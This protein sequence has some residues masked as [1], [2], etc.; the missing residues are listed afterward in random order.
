MLAF[1][2][3][4]WFGFSHNPLVFAIE[5]LLMPRYLESLLPDSWS[6]ALFVHLPSVVVPWLL[7]LVPFGVY[8]LHL[9]LSLS[10]KRLQT[11]C[12]LL[13]LL[14]FLIVLSAFGLADWIANFPRPD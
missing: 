7:F 2:G 12:F 5:P 1:M 10:V 9:V 11:F 8:F 3:M 14:L 13:V 4:Y 6:Y